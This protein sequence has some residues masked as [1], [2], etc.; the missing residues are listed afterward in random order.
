MFITPSAEIM[1]IHRRQLRD[2]RLT[3]WVCARPSPCTVILINRGSSRSM[4]SWIIISKSFS[5]QLRLTASLSTPGTKQSSNGKAMHP[6]HGVRGLLAQ[7]L[8]QQKTRSMSWIRPRQISFHRPKTRRA[9][10]AIESRLRAM[11]N[12]DK[13]NLRLSQ[14]KRFTPSTS[15]SMKPWC[16]TRIRRLSHPRSPQRP[17]ITNPR[18]PACSFDSKAWADRKT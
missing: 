13:T 9:L 17:R 2:T 11:S 18:K 8:R 5:P 12:K 14:R 10:S 16:K 4:S 1:L 7:K 3:T 6:K 15:Q